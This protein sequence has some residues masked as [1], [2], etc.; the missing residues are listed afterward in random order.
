MDASTLR[1]M[2]LDALLLWMG[3]SQ[4]NSTNHDMG[5]AELRFREI[6]LQM[7]SSQAQIRAAEAERLAAEASVKGAVAAERNAKY[8]FASVIVAAL[9]ALVSATSVLA[10][11]HPAWFK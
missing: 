8:M 3:R 11:L 9:A 7:E 1:D 2:S 4:P 5:M 10:T 6:K